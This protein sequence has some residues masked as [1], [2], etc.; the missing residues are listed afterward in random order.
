MILPNMPDSIQKIHVLGLGSIGTFVAHSLRSL[1]NPPSVT[2]LIHREGLYQDY[3]SKDGSISLQV[4]EK[5][6]P[7]EQRGF[8]FEL[9]NGSVTS[10]EPIHHLLVCVKASATVSALQPLKHRLGQH[11]TVCFF[12]NGMGQI[13]ELN[14][15][16]FKTHST[17][18]IYLFGIL[19]HGVYM[20]SSTEAV[21]SGVTGCVEIGIVPPENS[22][23]T[24]THSQF[25]LDQLLQSPALRCKK[26]EWID[27]LRVQLLK[28][29]TNCVL[30]PLTALLD[31]RNGEIKN[32]P[33]ISSLICKI[34]NEISL[35]FERLP[36]FQTLPRDGR[37]FSSATLEEVM[38]DT[39]DKTAGNSSSMREDILKGRATEIEYMNGWIVKRGAELNIA[40][41]INDFVTHLVLAKSSCKPS[42][43]I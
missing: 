30:N 4:G 7:Q 22:A 42:A 15:R 20:K 32:N 11:S 9:M 38:L 37:C 39:V 5:G 36:D 3:I 41:P 33:A 12:Q 17:R 43:S 40:C 23:S 26:L 35:V 14:E 13:E 21:L 8:D 29:A 1:P 6:T 34:L 10:L 24:T 31:V 19:R 28:L 27:L 16:I 18:P 25:L 2:L